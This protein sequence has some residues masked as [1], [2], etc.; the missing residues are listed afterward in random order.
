VPLFGLGTVAQAESPRRNVDALGEPVAAKRATGAVPLARAEAFRLVKLAPELAGSVA[1]KRASG[2]VP[3]ANAVAFKLVKLAPETAGNIAGKRASGTVPTE[4]TE[5]FKLVKEVPAAIMLAAFT[6]LAVKLPEASR[7]TI[8]LAPLEAE[9]VVLSF[10][11]VPEL[12][13]LAFI[14]VTFK[15]TA[16]LPSNDTLAAVAPPE[17]WK[18]L[19]VLSV[20]AEPEVLPVTLP[21]KLAVIVLA[22]KL[23]EASRATIVEAPFVAEAVVRAFNNVPVVMFDALVV[24]VVAEAAKPDTLDAVI[25]IPTLE[26][27][28]I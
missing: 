12:I 17:I 11:I 2:T 23:P 15:L 19:G 28:V 27:L 1:G 13:T 22:E 24:S 7:A 18:F 16:A 21:V 5:A 6:L 3:E 4:S 8:V 25:A 26:A 20:A 14:A 10:G 9:A